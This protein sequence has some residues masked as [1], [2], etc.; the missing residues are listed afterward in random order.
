MQGGADGYCDVTVC[1]TLVAAPGSPAW[2]VGW[3]YQNC[4]FSGDIQALQ[5]IM[6]D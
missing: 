2:P 4:S 6:R 5:M 3:L 1:R